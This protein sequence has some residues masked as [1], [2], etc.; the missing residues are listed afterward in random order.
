VSRSRHSGST[1][2]SAAR[3]GGLLALGIA[4][5][6]VK[7]VYFKLRTCS[8]RSCAGP[9][10]RLNDLEGPTLHTLVL[11]VVQGSPFNQNHMAPEI[12]LLGN[13]QLFNLA[14][15]LLA[16]TALARGAFPDIVKA[17]WLVARRATTH[18]VPAFQ[19]PLDC[20][21]KLDVDGE[22]VRPQHARRPLLCRVAAGQLGRGAL[23]LSRAHRDHSV[24][25]RQDQQPDLTEDC[26]MALASQAFW[27]TS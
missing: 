21:V 20:S 12:P 25:L 22:S 16:G 13:K 3:R 17:D 2:P 1:L 19:T 14:V 15:A 5:R 7:K 8:P 24:S 11:H 18:N 4:S 27:H 23:P 26:C 9:A 10:R 6:S